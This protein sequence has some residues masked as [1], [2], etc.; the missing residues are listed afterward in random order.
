MNYYSS[1]VTSEVG[2][3]N[4]E[5]VGC[6]L[7]CSRFPKFFP[8]TYRQ[9][10]PEETDWFPLF[11]GKEKILHGVS[12]LGNDSGRFTVFKIILRILCLMMTSLF[13]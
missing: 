5:R 1:P 10:N 7:R 9:N 6:L 13:L 8:I 4:T 12:I 11:V 2:F 3:L